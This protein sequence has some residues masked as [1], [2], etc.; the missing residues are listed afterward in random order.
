[1][2]GSLRGYGAVCPHSA[3][4]MLTPSMWHRNS[5]NSGKGMRSVDAPDCPRLEWHQDGGRTIRAKLPQR[6]NLTEGLDLTGA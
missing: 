3:V 5:L 2:T 6:V 1:M 4:G